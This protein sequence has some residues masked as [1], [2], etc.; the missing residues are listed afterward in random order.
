[1]KQAHPAAL[2]PPHRSQHQ[3]ATVQSQEVGEFLSNKDLA[4]SC[5]LFLVMN[6]VIFLKQAEPQGDLASSVQ[7]LVLYREIVCMEKGG[8]ESRKMSL[9]V[10][11]VE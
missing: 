4:Q 2:P 7:G 10:Y 8:K 3:L 11:Y 6:T 5:S 9:A 1:M